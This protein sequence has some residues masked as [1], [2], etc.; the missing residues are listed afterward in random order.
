MRSWHW[1][2]RSW[3]RDELSTAAPIGHQPT[4]SRSGTI[5]PRPGFCG[6][7]RAFATILVRSVTLVSPRN[8]TITAFIQAECKIQRV[9]NESNHGSASILRRIVASRRGSI[10]ASAARHLELAFRGMMGTGKA[11][12]WRSVI[13]AKSL[14]SRTRSETWLSSR[15]PLPRRP[16]MRQSHRCWISTSLRW[17]ST[18]RA[19]AT[20]WRA[21]C[22]TRIRP[23]WNASD[24]RRTMAGLLSSTG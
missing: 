7:S 22:R 5:F 10:G 19:S 4:L 21:S 20:R 1:N 15:T 16:P 11:Q 12:S 14:Q 24:G 6:R 8:V 13:C 9:A 23:G 18:R 2:D 3:G 17:C